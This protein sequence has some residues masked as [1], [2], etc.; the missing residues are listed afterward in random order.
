[1]EVI[2]SLEKK[3]ATDYLVLFALCSPTAL[4]YAYRTSKSK[5]M[6]KQCYEQERNFRSTS[7]GEVLS[8]K[9]QK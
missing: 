1:M 5:S 2:K 6:N 4:F 9:S 7:Q 3:S 8:L